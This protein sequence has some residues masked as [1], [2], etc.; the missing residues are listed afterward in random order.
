MKYRQKE[1]Q[2]RADLAFEGV[3]SK[4]YA[5]QRLELA[6]QQAASHPLSQAPFIGGHR[7]DLAATTSVV[8]QGPEKCSEPAVTERRSLRSEQFRMSAP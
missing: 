1:V 6:S 2:N 5:S 7:G 8:W 4:L 3:S